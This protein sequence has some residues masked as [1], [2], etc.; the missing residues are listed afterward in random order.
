MA[1]KIEIAVDVADSAFT[2]FA[3]KFKAYS[4]KLDA[5]PG[6]M[7][8]V[9]RSSEESAVHFEA[10]AAAVS[11]QADA[12]AKIASGSVT[13]RQN[14]EA[15]ARHWQ[16]L[17][18]S[19]QGVATNIKEATVSLLKWT[20]VTS[21]VAGIAGGI[22]GYGFSNVAES[23]SGSRTAA[24]GLGA[25]YGGRSSFLVNFRRMTDPEGFLSRVNEVE[26]RADNVP[27][28]ALGLS[29]QQA[30]GDTADVAANA[31]LQLKRLVDNV[32]DPRFLADTLRA[33]RADELISLNQAQ[34]LRSMSPQEVQQ[35]VASY[36]QDKGRLSLGDDT[37]KKYQD[38]TTR[39]SAATK[40]IEN[41]FIKRLGALTPGMTKLTVSFDHVVDVLMKKDGPLSQ[42]LGKLNEGVEWL[43]KN[44]DTPEFQT[45]VES[46][47]SG[48]GKVAS[49]VGDLLTG[50]VSLAKWFGITPA[51]ASTGGTGT[52]AF[53]VGT[54][55]RAK[56]SAG[57]ARDMGG[58]GGG[59]SGSGGSGGDGSSGS[60]MD[61]LAKIESDNRNI[62]SGV[63][64]DYPGQPGS[65]SQGFFQIDT[66]TWRQ[67]AA[68]AGVDLSKYPNAMSAPREVQARVAAMIPLKRF[69]PRTRRMLM[70]QFGPLDTDRPVGRLGPHPDN[71]GDRSPSSGKPSNTT[72]RVTI[73]KPTG[74]DPSTAAAAAAGQ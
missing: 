62:P 38:F 24:M 2:A 64:H 36:R 12:I 33:N 70:Q 5:T 56:N 4:E 42:W 69:G 66:P 18:L 3:T 7:A 72:T 47:V 55:L 49:A 43:A 60:F 74:S 20:G 45:K 27:L 41:T 58:G 44:I 8:K 17:R 15:T 61:A 54:G 22:A 46:F 52:G 57:G 53:G 23:V 68:R 40:K 6:A 73:T 71:E 28:R 50:I 34:A 30:Q 63:D 9:S 29:Q 37:Q 13:M 67:F 51:E 59:S 16:G 48:I 21:L 35:L 39:M 11:D 10:L 25:T 31:V 19:T 26:H 14:S 65:K 1:A 32:K